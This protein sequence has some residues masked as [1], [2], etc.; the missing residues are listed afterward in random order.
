MVS[1]L[2]V[3]SVN[4]VFTVP[5]GMALH[6]PSTEAFCALWGGSKVKYP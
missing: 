3:T 2:G 4:V 1:G 6:V 5:W